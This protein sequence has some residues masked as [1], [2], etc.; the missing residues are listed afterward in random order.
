MTNALAPWAGALSVLTPELATALGPLLRRLDALIDARETVIGAEGEP[1]GYGGLARGRRPERLLTSEWLLAEEFPEEFLRRWSEGELLELETELRETRSRGQVVVL[2]DAGPA[3]AGAARLVQLAA[4]L[5]LH[6]RAA[7]RGSELLVGVLGDPPGRLIGGDLGELLPRWLK[8]RQHADPEPED[9]AY[10]ERALDP[11]AQCWLLAS[12]RLA[13]RLPARR[14]TVASEEAGWSEAGAS[15]V[16]VRVDGG[17]AVE[18]PLPPVGVAVRA[19]RGSGFRSTAQLAAQLPAVGGALPAFTSGAATLLVRGRW[20]SVLVALGL[21]GGGTVDGAA[22]ARRHK[23]PG[24]AVA[25]GRIGRRLLALYVRNDWLELYVS[26]R[27]LSDSEGYRVKSAAVGL[28]ELGSPEFAELMAQPVLPLLREGDALVLPVAGRWR[29]IEPGGRVSTDGVVLSTEG[30]HPFMGA[31]EPRLAPV[32][33]PAEAAGAPHLVHGGGA[34][35]WSED[36]RTWEV[37]SSR[38]KSGRIELGDGRAEVIGLVEDGFTPVLITRT[39]AAGLVRAVRADAVRVRVDRT[40]TALSGGATAPAVHPRLPLLA[41][42]TGPGR[43]VVA[44]AA[45]GR[46]HAVIRSTE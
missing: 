22:R 34:L 27:E 39:L 36:G 17:P 2:V 4:L 30:G 26:G 45:D 37:R 35:G 10:A 15:R 29:R 41:A 7:A 13:A 14:R 21:S 1:D 23:L 24:Q 44:S 40:L 20:P 31:W 46:T 38:G 28:P 32:Q 8:A 9:V 12:P 18:L 19:L 33:L 5:V 3:Q 6:R 16:A 25:A 42:E 11:A 43:V